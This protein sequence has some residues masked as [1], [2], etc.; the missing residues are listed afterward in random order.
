MKK[1]REILNIKRPSLFYLSMPILIDY[2]LGF[3]NN[4]NPPYFKLSILFVVFIL[5]NCIYLKLYSIIKKMPII[6]ALIHSFL[7]LFY[8]YTYVLYFLNMI[9]NNTINLD[10]RAKYIL[11]AVLF[12]ISYFIYIFRN[13]LNNIMYVTNVFFIILCFVKIIDNIDLENI[14]KVNVKSYPISLNRIKGNPVLLII[15]DEYASP[16]ELIKIYKDSSIFDYK[17]NLLKNNWIAKNNMF[18]ADTLTI[19]SL[20]SLFNFNFQLNDQFLSIPLSKKRLRTSTLYDSLEK[21]KIKFY[22]YGIFDIGKSKAMTK[23]AFN[24][25]E[26]SNNDFILNFFS[27]TLI[28]PLLNFG[29]EKSWNKHNRLNIES[30]LEKIDS[31]DNNSFV[32][33][34]LLMPHA[35]FEFHGAKYSHENLANKNKLSNYI[36]YWK[37]SNKILINLLSELTKKKYRIIL[38]G[39]HG[40]RGDIRINPHYT[41]TAFFGFNPVS[42]DKIKS[43]QDLGSLINASF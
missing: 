39:D 25:K 28:S 43:V 11:P 10:L 30:T 16:C 19:N 41:F 3:I 13:K 8:Y 31:I 9:N 5:F 36:D 2:N 35:P 7:F 17:K 1:I 37:F 29:R 34:H 38:S 32:Y 12:F 40:Y 26:Y 42:I 21:R 15:V 18:S 33:I 14:N 23:V 27:N 20:A 6:F 22:N 4:E 24:Y